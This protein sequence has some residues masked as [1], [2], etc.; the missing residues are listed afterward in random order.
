MITGRITHDLEPL[1][2]DVYLRAKDGSLLEVKTVL[3]TGFNAAF[4]FPKYLFESL[5]LEYFGEGVFILAD[6][7]SVDE[8]IYLGEVVIDNQPYIVEMT[9]TESDIALL[10]M[11]ML[12]EREA[13]FNLRNMTVTVL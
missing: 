10:G 7:N 1:L 12:L 9:M 2:N 13:I 6:G 11:E 8:T 4:C 5:K 3:D